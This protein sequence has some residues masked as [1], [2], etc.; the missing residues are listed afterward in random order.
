[1]LT[2]AKPLAT[3]H[4]GQM[5]TAR[6]RRRA[7]PAVAWSAA[8]AIA[9]AGCSAA[10]AAQTANPTSPGSPAGT[11]AATVAGTAAANPATVSIGSIIGTT[12]PTPPPTTTWVRVSDP[13]VP[14]TF[15][16]PSTWGK[17]VA[18]Q[19]VEGGTAVGWL[20]AAGP[21][22]S[23]IGGDF[24]VPG[25]VIGISGAPG[26][27]P[28]A[29]VAGD[30]YSSVCKTS[31]PAADASDPAVK[32]AYRTWEQCGTGANGFLLV[33]GIVPVGGAGLV[34]I[35]LQGASE[36]DLAYLQHMLG[37]LA[38][39]TP[40]ATQPPAAATQGPATGALF[41]ITMDICQNQHGQGV[42]EGTFRNTDTVSHVFRVEV[43]FFDPNGAFLNN[44]AWKSPIDLPPGLATRW[45]AVVPSGLPGVPVT[46]QVKD[47]QIIR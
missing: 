26:Q 39:A 38:A 17:Y 13:G 32:A 1:M 22:P 11:A 35:V 15:E 45:Q 31:S 43:W 16:V 28:Q 5:T 46:C 2:R 44:S 34:G 7:R 20:L 30:D 24:T 33:I 12:P 19:W 10:P 6:A 47:V 40:T 8:L 4:G 37:S 29:L 18:R 27:T 14:F 41:A 23:K 42:A 25:I 21:D 3:I 36:A 9:A